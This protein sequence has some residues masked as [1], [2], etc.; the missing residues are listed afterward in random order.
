M[1]VDG[2][3]IPFN[4]KSDM[5]TIKICKQTYKE[6]RKSTYLDLTSDLPCNPEEINQ[7]EISSKIYEMLVA[8]IQDEDQYE[9]R[10][11]LKNKIRQVQ[12]TCISDW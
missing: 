3:I 7:E 4:I 8:R 12:D 5:M 10:L 9:I 11:N 1:D 6:P 2:Y